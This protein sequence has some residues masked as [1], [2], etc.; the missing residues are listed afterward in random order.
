M[1]SP[2]V[3]IVITTYNR[4]AQLCN[5]FISVSQQSYKDYEIIVI[6]SGTDDETPK[7]CSQ[8]GAKYIKVA[9]P[10]GYGNPAYPINVGL[11]LAKGDIVV[12]QNAECKHTDPNT[13]EKFVSLVTDNNAVFANVIALKEDGS[14]MREYSGKEVPDP[15]FFCGAMKRA[16]FEKLRGMDE[17]FVTPH[18]EDQDFK[19]RMQKA[20]IEFVFSDILVHHQWHEYLATEYKIAKVLYEKKTREMAAGEIGITRNLNRE[21]G[22]DPPPP[23]PPPPPPPPCRCVDCVKKRTLGK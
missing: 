1:K 4:P 15:C 9:L 3:S 19:D 2:K 22:T 21:W 10:L 23:L 18:Y 5:T 7:I 14:R 8:Y 17:D 12:L 11:R 20:G 13:I 16:W 6:D